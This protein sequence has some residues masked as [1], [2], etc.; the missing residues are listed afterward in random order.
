MS[1]M[2]KAALTKYLSTKDFENCLLDANL[3][4]SA[5]DI[6]VAEESA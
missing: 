1:S 3:D 4:L 5:Q 6:L 2:V